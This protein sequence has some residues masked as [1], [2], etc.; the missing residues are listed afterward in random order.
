MND[1][2]AFDTLTLILFLICFK[3]N[4]VILIPS[5]N[6]GAYTERF[7]ESDDDSPNRT[8]IILNILQQ[9]QFRQ[10]KLIMNVQP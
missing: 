9:R 1:K 2:L 5:M 8:S 3:I 10:P 4:Y 7:F 6:Y